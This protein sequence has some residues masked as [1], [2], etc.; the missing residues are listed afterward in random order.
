MRRKIVSKRWNA[1]NG[2]LDVP[3][4][5]L[6]MHARPIRHGANLQ[7]LIAARGIPRKYHEFTARE[8]R[9]QILEIVLRL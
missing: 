9:L 8:S 7:T 6:Y 5:R 4:N 3:R 1:V 2:R